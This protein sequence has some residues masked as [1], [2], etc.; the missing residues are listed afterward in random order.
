MDCS[1]DCER[2]SGELVRSIG[3]ST[4][5][6]CRYGDGGRFTSALVYS[7]PLALGET[8]G[9]T[10]SGLADAWEEE[11]EDDCGLPVGEKGRSVGMNGECGD[12]RCRL[13]D[14]RAA[15]RRAEGDCW[16]AYCACC[17]EA[18]VLTIAGGAAAR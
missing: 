10:G 13:G 1:E 6:A 4:V 7:R 3:V 16:A 18:G 11:L 9:A 8:R 14:C 5:G 15:D 2:E 12:T 17:L